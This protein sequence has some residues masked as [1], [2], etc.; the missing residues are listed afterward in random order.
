MNS[1]WSERAAAARAGE[2]QRQ[3]DHIARRLADPAI[4]PNDVTI[5]AARRKRILERY[6][7]PVDRLAASQYRG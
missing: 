2:Q 3:L 5:L 4:D 1:T 6:S 7:G